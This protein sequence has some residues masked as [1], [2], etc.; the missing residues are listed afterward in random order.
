M[1]RQIADRRSQIADSALL[2]PGGRFSS[3]ETVASTVCRRREPDGTAQARRRASGL[4]TRYAGYVKD[5]FRTAMGKTIRVDESDD[6]ML[7]VKV[8]RDGTWM[9]APLGMIGSGSP[10]RPDGSRRG[11]SAPSQR[12]ANR[13]AR[14]GGDEARPYRREHRRGRRRPGQRD[15]GRDRAR[16]HLV[17]V[18]DGYLPCVDGL[19]RIPTALSPA[20]TIL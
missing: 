20:R 2:P 6:G 18:Q 16:G 7:T 13:S 14:H 5:I 9:D 12:E 17:S 1:I 19:G 15:A 4:R 3:S 11:R 8:L 10:R